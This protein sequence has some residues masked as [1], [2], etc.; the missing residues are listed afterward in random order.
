MSGTWQVTSRG[1]SGGTSSTASWVKTSTRFARRFRFGSAGAQFDT[2]DQTGYTLVVYRAD[3]LTLTALSAAFEAGASVGRKT[4][5][6]RITEPLLRGRP[7]FHM[8]LLNGDH[9][10][11]VTLFQVSGEAEVRGILASDISD[12]AIQEALERYAAATE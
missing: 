6:I 4:Q 11:V 9:R 2:G 1:L 12:A 3:G 7:S 5:D 8:V 10:Q